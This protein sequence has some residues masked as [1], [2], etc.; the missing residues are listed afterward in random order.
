M[1]QEEIYRQ[2]QQLPNV[3]VL[4]VPRGAEWGRANRAIEQ[5]AQI[6]GAAPVRTPHLTVQ[7][8][9]N[10]GEEQHTRLVEQLAGVAR[11]TAPLSIIVA[12][13]NTD[14]SR[15]PRA[16]GSL[17]L[18]VVKTAELHT[19]YVQLTRAVQA[20]GIAP[21]IMTADNWLPHIKVFDT[22]SCTIDEALHLLSNSSREARPPLV[23]DLSFRAT[24]L[25]LSHREV[26]GAVPGEWEIIREFPLEGEKHA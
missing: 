4:L 19:L 16:A 13:R 3:C 20:A 24:T 17:I 21:A 6:C 26:S 9:F 1:S 2:F 15:F 5:A 18:D 25:A 22:L 23:A 7:Y 14:I 10:V 8:L 12:A 11:A